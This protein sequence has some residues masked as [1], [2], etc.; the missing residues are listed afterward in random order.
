MVMCT[1]LASEKQLLT[2]G[3]AV[4]ASVG[5]SWSIGGL[6]LELRV[7][8]FELRALSSSKKTAADR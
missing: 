5:G 2:S 3:G 7:S 4:C 6:S 1:L 8:S